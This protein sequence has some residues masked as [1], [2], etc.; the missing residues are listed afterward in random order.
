MSFAPITRAVPVPNSNILAGK[1][2]AKGK[3][4]QKEKRGGKK[5]FV[6]IL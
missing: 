4:N 3:R 1:N 5:S 6:L 2:G